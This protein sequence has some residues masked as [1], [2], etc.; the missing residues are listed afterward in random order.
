MDTDPR[1]NA[2]LPPEDSWRTGR[3]WV[4]VLFGLLGVA[5]IAIAVGELSSGA[6]GTAA[7]RVLTWL[8][9]LVALAFLA[10]AVGELRRRAMVDARGVHLV[11]TLRRRT[12]PWRE[13]IEVRAGRPTVLGDRYGY[14]EQ[15]GGGRV[16][17]PR[18][19]D[20]LPLLERWHAAMSPR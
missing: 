10:V 20:R 12:L 18:S 15:S 17:L 4:G 16:E 9:L 2:G 7:G 3:A 5:N 8:R 14:L 13:V 19:G 6:D 1:G 11:A